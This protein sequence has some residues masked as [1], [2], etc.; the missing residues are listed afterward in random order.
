MT[1]APHHATA[2]V[3]PVPLGKREQTKAANRE[4]IRTA[5]LEAFTDLGFGATTVRDIVRRTSLA[6]GTFYNY[7]ADKDAILSEL[8]AEHV[9]EADRRMTVAR[10]AAT[11]PREAVERG[12]AAY[13]GLLMERGDLLAMFRRNAGTIRGYAAGDVLTH[14]VAS[15]REDLDRLL[16]DAGAEGLDTELLAAG[17]MGAGMDIAMR[18]AERGGDDPAVALAVLRALLV[19]GILGRAGA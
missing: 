10:A 6:S 3:A 9:A 11:T 1:D 4:E 19:D 15:F 13:F 5:A 16:A 14:V 12:A 2:E 18:F 7:Y 8:I 17:V